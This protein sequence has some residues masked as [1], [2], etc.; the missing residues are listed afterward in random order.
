MAA[1]VSGS[2]LGLSTGSAGVLNLTQGNAAFGRGGEQV[3]VNV[4][5]GNLVLQRQDELLVGRGP[6]TAV[7]RTYNSLGLTDGDNNDN[8]RTGFHHQ[9]LL[10]GG[11]RIVR[12]EAD[13]AEQNY[14][15]DTASG[16]YRTSD[17]GGASDTLSYSAATG[18]WLWTDG[19]SGTSETWQ[20]SA[21]LGR[22]QL[23]SQAD[24][25]GNAVTYSYNGSG[26]LISVTSAN[27]SGSHAIRRAWTRHQDYRAHC[28][29]P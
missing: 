24:A 2:S 10:S 4:G 17:G 11:S 14:G 7:L 8:W 9:L 27:S 5:S 26:L 1:Y 15:Y 18:K 23:L 12:V 29:C 20:W 21:T 13:G 28:L 6:D 19:A 22:H 16:I 25:S 3:H